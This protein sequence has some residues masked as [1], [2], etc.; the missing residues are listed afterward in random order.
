ML[1]DATREIG[2]RVL[3]G[4]TMDW[5]IFHFAKCRSACRNGVA[6]AALEIPKILNKK[7]PL[8]R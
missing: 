7:N 5:S 6:V 4:Y 8:G 3:F 1:L 2:W